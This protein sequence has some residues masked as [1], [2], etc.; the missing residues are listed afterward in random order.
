MK[1]QAVIRLNFASEK[2]LKVM[3]EALKP[4][5]KTPSTRRSKVQMKSEANSLT[6]NFRAR[7]TSALRAAI[8]SYLRWILLTKTVIESVNGLQ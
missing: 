2:K 3:L 4:E 5:T 1:A 7:D 6:L 8:N